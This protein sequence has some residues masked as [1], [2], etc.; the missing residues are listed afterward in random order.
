MCAHMRENVG[1]VPRNQPVNQREVEDDV[2]LVLFAARETHR[3][4][5]ATKEN[6][7]VEGRANLEIIAFEASAGFD[8]VKSYGDNTRARS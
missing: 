2:A 5:V 3:A 6:E 8:G 7:A 4:L 1:A